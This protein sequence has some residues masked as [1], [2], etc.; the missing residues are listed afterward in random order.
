VFLSLLQTVFLEEMEM[1]SILN[2]FEQFGYSLT[3]AL[4]PS[5]EEIRVVEEFEIR[6]KKNCVL[7]ECP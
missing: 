1:E 3:R 5:Y 4:Q 6:S 2:F 7:D